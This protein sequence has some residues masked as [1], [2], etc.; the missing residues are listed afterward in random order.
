M[1]VMLD[2]R[3]AHDFGIGRYIRGLV[4]GFSAFEDDVH[5]LLIGPPA[6]RDSMMPVPNAEWID[7]DAP[8]YS[9]RELRGV[10]RLAAKHRADVL[11]SPHYVTPIS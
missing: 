9:L 2:C 7:Y 3:K 4:Q 5:L 10:G 8:H 6:A 11:H 1:R